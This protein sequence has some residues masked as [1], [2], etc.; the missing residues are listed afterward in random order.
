MA[1]FIL[2]GLVALSCLRGLVR[3]RDGL[4]GIVLIAAVQDPLRKLVPGVPG[5]LALAVVPAL[6]V[7]LMA[8]MGTQRFW[9]S[10]FA[11]RYPTVGR[12]MGWFGLACIPAALTS[13]FYGPG[14]W[15]L[16]ILGAFSYGVLLEAIFLG[17]HFSRSIKDLR[18]FVGFYCVVTTVMLSGAAIQYFELWP[19]SL[20]VGTEALGTSWIRHMPGVQIQMI[21]GFYRS[22]DVMGWH[23]ATTAMFA[24][25]LSLTTRGTS[26]RIW[27]VLGA[28]AVVALLLCG[29]RKMVY[30]LPVFGSILIML[31]W[32]ARASGRAAG[33]LV[34]LA[35]VGIVLTEGFEVGQGSDVGRYYTAGSVDV[36]DRLN[37]NGFN[38]LLVTFDQTGF[39]G[40]GLGVATPGSQHLNVARPRAWQEGAASRILV[41]LGVPGL[42]AFGVL[43]MTM[44]VAGWRVTIRQLRARAPTS[45][46]AAGFFA[47]FLAN[48]GSLVVSGQILAD[49]AIATLIGL[50]IG[51]VLSLDGVSVPRVEPG[52]WSR[53]ASAR[54]ARAD[55]RIDVGRPRAP[56]PYADARRRIPGGLTRH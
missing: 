12:A 9:K 5:Y 23:A 41:E 10:G 13:A 6:A 29:R 39:F 43:V 50:A 28:I 7:A 15:M 16:T 38:S 55:A 11:R 8:L 22:P 25:I 32:K 17:F 34:G 49:A 1:Q 35:V 46:Y 36:L 20:A 54:F 37:S 18:R 52:A 56:S 4:F 24:A 27:L 3:W 2:A 40:S 45:G 48:V 19:G 51:F 53:A 33:L 31:Y 42:L 44:L 21:S 47:F 14:S 30:M 26:R